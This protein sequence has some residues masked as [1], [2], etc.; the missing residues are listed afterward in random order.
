M[1]VTARI[2][3]MIDTRPAGPEGLSSTWLG[4]S[5]AAM[6]GMVSGKLAGATAYA[7]QAATTTQPTTRHKV[8]FTSCSRNQ[9][10][11]SPAARY[12]CDFLICHIYE[13]K[14]RINDTKPILHND[15]HNSEVQLHSGRVGDARLDLFL[16]LGLCLFESL[17]LMLVHGADSIDLLDT[18]WAKGDL[19]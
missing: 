1:A 19:C 7:P 9:S 14:D 12:A 10:N 3:L 11:R 8:L 2:R 15:T 17:R 4:F 18:A 16:E 5:P 13:C 6:P